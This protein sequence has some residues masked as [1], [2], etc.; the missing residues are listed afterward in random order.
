MKNPRFLFLL[1]TLFAI[2][3]IH[4]QTK[5]VIDDRAGLLTDEVV[6]E[7]GIRLAAKGIEYVTTVDFS[8]PCDYYFTS[9]R[10]QDRDVTVSVS[11]CDDRLLG[12]RSL[13]AGIHDVALTERSFLIAYTIS[14]IVSGTG[15]PVAKAPEDQA[16]VQDVSPAEESMAGPSAN[17][18]DT[19]YFFAPT[20]FNLKKGQLYYNTVYFLLHD[21]QYGIS[22]QFSFGMG[23]TIIGLPVYFTPKLSIPTGKRS[24]IALG[25]M[26]ILGTYGSDV[27]GNLIYGTFSQGGMNG[28]FSLGGGYLA[29]NDSDITGRTSAGVINISGVTR[30]SPYIYLLSENYFFGLN[31]RRTAW[32]YDETTYES[33]S[34]EFDQRLKIWYGIAGFRFISKSSDF[35]SWQAGLTYMIIIPEEIPSR[36]NNWETLARE[37]TNLIAFPTISYTRKFGKRY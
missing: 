8:A 1:L 11:D 12:S 18:H 34:E 2:G 25:D 31:A 32:R 14:E 36:Y 24:A 22:D 26:L 23:T 16:A 35:V 17:E 15:D 7:L 29:T 27:V 21:I 9:I 3:P 10:P 30:V 19:R 33:Y 37:G 4:S 5:L 6:D 13:G 28:N 20:A